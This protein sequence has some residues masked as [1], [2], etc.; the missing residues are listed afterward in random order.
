[1]L[2]TDFLK[3]SSL[4]VFDS[5]NEN[6]PDDAREITDVYEDLLYVWNFKNSNIKVVNWR[7]AQTSSN[8]GKEIKHQVL[9]PSSVPNFTVSKISVSFGGSSISIS[10]KHGLSILEL[11]HRFGSDGIYQDGKQQ[12][13]CKTINIHEHSLSQVEVV[14]AK[15][16]PNSPTDSHLLVL[17]S[18]NSLKVYDEGVLKHVWRVGPL[19]SQIDNN[20]SYLKSLGYTAIDFDIGSPQVSSFESPNNTLEQS[21]QDSTVFSVPKRNAEQKKVEWPIVILRGNGTIY[22]MTAGLN[23]EK[24]RLQ[25][26]ITVTPSQKDN[27]GD[28]SC[29]L[30]VIPTNPMTIV[31]AENSGILHHALLIENPNTEMSF[32]ET[33]TVLPND[34]TLYVMENIEL[35]LGLQND[36]KSESSSCPI[37]LKRDPVNEQRYFC[38]HDTGLHGITIGFVQKLQKFTEDQDND[39]DLSLDVPSRAEYILSTKAFNNSKVNAIIGFGILQLPSGFFAVMSSGQ[40]VSLN[41][42]K[43]MLPLV[44]DLNVQA[45]RLQDIKINN[46]QLNKVPFDQ[47]IR[48]LLKSDVS[49]PILQL[50]KTKPPSSQQTFQLLMNTLQIM[51]EKQFARHD[52]VR[53][54]ISKRIKILELMKHQQ[55]DEIAELLKSKEQIQEKAYKLADMHEDILEKQ[56]N[57]QKRIQDIS[58][59]ASLKVPASN[60]KEFIETI[61]KYKTIIDKLTTDV[62]QIKA[63]N[64]IQKKALDNWSKTNEENIKTSMP[65][66]QEETI[67]EFLN[68]MMRQIQG[69]KTDVNRIHSVVDY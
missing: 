40:V 21:N 62:K 41:T 13:T 1:M 69:L 28:D 7:A 3:F 45:P 6:L 25:G 22:V 44:T 24:P 37:Y 61:K 46:D 27:Y 51:R 39:D 65:P 17:M 14:Q 12:I 26:P 4:K 34:W 63:K 33:K 19:P 47:H 52:K 49:Q 15:W 57:L 67:K 48:A 5:V 68:D 42:V 11:P 58:R 64:E 10:G 36:D 54:E 16:H 50:D 56:Q 66:K 38:Y 35:E 29:S 43:T 20:L 55:K 9:I 23:T 8:K 18:D 2:D 30:L 32:N 59:L 60:E 53:Q 31:I